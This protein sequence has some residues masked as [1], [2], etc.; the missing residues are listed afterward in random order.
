M[1]RTVTPLEDGEQ[2]RFGA[3][4]RE[5]PES[6]LFVVQQLSERHGQTPRVRSLSQDPL[7]QDPCDTFGHVAILGGGGE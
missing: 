6:K 1:T 4:P 2:F 3:N 7:E 5:F